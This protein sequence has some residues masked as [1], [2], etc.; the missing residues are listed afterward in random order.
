MPEDLPDAREHLLQ[1]LKEQ[2]FSLFDRLHSVVLRSNHA[3][4]DRPRLCQFEF[5]KPCWQAVFFDHRQEQVVQILSLAQNVDV[6]QG[7]RRLQSQT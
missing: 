5:W 3:L 2:G 6:T 7:V 1:F 4:V